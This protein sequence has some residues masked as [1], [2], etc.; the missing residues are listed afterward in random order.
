MTV[1]YIFIYLSTLGDAVFNAETYE[2]YVESIPATS[3]EC[4]GEMNEGNCNGDVCVYDGANCIVTAF[5]DSGPLENACGFDT[6]TNLEGWADPEGY[7]CD[8]WS[9]ESTWCD[10]YGSISTSSVSGL[11]ANEACCACGGG[12]ESTFQSE[13]SQDDYTSTDSETEYIQYSGS[14]T[15][16]VNHIMFFTCLWSL[17]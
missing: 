15:L 5:D 12:S 14:V 7:T 16:F 1:I 8:T 10:D 11:T 4:C 9:A 6:C 3:S 13:S 17:L 2:Y